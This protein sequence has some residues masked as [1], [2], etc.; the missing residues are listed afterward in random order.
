MSTLAS[1]KKSRAQRKTS[2]RTQVES[3]SSNTSF[4]DDRVWSCQTNKAGIGSAVFRFLEASDDDIKYYTEELDYDEDAVPFWVHLHQHGFKGSNGKWMIENCPTSVVKRDCPV[5]EANSEIVDENGGWN[6]MDDNHPG[7]KLVRNRKRK[8]VYYSNILIIKDTANPE[9]EG[10]IKIFRYG[11][12][13]HDIIL[14]QLMPTFDDD[15]PCNV[16]DYWEGRDF[17]LKIVR[18]DGYANYDQSS[19]EDITQIAESDD[20]IEEI[21]G[22]QFTLSEFISEDK[23]KSYEDLVKGFEKTQGNA[24][25]KPRS[26]DDEGGDGGDEGEGEDESS[27]PAKSS[28]RASLKK[29]KPKAESKT[30]SKPKA[31]P[32]PEGE[33]DNDDDDDAYFSSLL[34]E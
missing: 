12:A 28:R 21:L 16:A 4:K 7:K 24:K 15:E 8:E 6:A 31:D 19:W 17:K 1:R 32:K 30:K 25:S 10:E 29:S 9:N 3:E 34:E 23:Y 18:K 33:G 13:I 2:L 27:A 11:K 22:K 5:C 20:E 14:A 26:M